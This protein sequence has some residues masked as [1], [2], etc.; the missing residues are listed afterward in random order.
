[1]V[2]CG[3]PNEAKLANKVFRKEAGMDFTLTESQEMLRATVR[4][5]AEREVEP[6][7]VQIDEEDVF[8]TETVRKMAETGL[9]GFGYPE[10]IGGRGGGTVEQAIV[11]EEMARVSAAVSVIVVTSNEL[12]ASPIF[13]H[14]TEMQRSEYLTPLLQG[15]KMGAFALTEPGAGSDVAAMATT[16]TRTDGGYLLNGSKQFISNAPEAGF[17]VVFATLDKSLGYRGV[18]AFIIE[19]DTPGFVVGKYNRKMG[20]RGSSNNELAFE[21]CFIPEANRLGEEGRGF[22]IALETI[23]ACRVGIAAQ[24]TGVAQ[25]AY[26]KAVVYSKERHQ[27]GQA[28]SGFQ[29]I[30]WMLADMATQIDAARLLVY[31]AAWLIDNGLPFAKE[32]SMAKLFA[33]ETAT[34]VAS[35]AV[36]IHGGYGYMKDYPVERY[37]RDA[38]IMEIFEGT[39]EMQRMTIAR[40]ILRE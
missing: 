16:A 27:F 25:A 30:Q 32:A 12:A 29:A 10:E 15:E 11:V 40:H 13:H 22:R 36:Q 18:T 33:S 1:V 39:S 9:M 24:A 4:D 2:L 6:I 7:A 37:F 34:N 28:I 26:E 19:K 20:I 3:G 31:R 38:R 35:K 5:F 17:L 23:D 21:D 8:P 14:G